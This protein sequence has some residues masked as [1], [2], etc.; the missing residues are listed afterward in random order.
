MD[1]RVIDTFF[2]LLRSAVSGADALTDEQRNTALA[3]AEPLY[4]LAKQH[5]LAHLVG[6][7]LFE[8]NLT[9]VYPRFEKQHLLSVFRHE[10]IVFSQDAICDAL[11]AAKIPHMPLKGAFLRAVYPEP[12]MRT[13][14]D[15]DI[16]VKRE[17]HG[18]AVLCLAENGYSEG[19]RSSHDVTVHREGHIPTDLHF[20]LWENGQS[21]AVCDILD[22]VWDVATPME[23]HSYTYQM[24]DELFYFFH[25]AH[26]A[27]HTELGGCG[28]R[29]FLDLWF[30]DKDADARQEKRDAL[31]EK[32]GL[33]AFAKAARRLSRVWFS[34][35]P[36]DSVSKAL[37]T[38]IL[39]GGVYG[40]AENRITLQ[41]QQRGGRVRYAL[42]R[43]FVSFEELKVYYP[44]L[45]AHRVLFPLMQVRRWFKVIFC[46]GFRRSMHELHYNHHVSEEDADRMKQL[47][48]DLGLL[49]EED[50]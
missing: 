15:V 45:K 6:F 41:Q 13:S 46:G 44:I 49:P 33:L 26:M 12:W 3:S 42:S 18:R 11:A 20:R 14:C 40:T 47:L 32:G 22:T 24:P 28:V 19:E 2:A 1:R 7:S 30:L 21:D 27:K 4:A 10:S 50:S 43:I 31:L 36:H 29:P 23:G 48:N 35:Q 34:G 16:L 5:D 39:S 25:M 37:E 38:Y 8:A 17:D 9:E